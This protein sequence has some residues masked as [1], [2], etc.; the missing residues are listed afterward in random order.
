MHYHDITGTEQRKATV[1]PKDK[2]GRKQQAADK[3]VPSQVAPLSTERGG[4]VHQAKSSGAN[5]SNQHPAP[6]NPLG[7][8]QQAIAQSAVG[9]GIRHSLGMS[10]PSVATTHGTQAATTVAENS[11][12]PIPSGVQE[13]LSQLAS[14]YQNSIGDLPSYPEGVGSQDQSQGAG[15]AAYND[16]FPSLLSRNSSLVDLAMIPTLD[17][18]EPFISTPGMRFVD[19]PQPEVDPSNAPPGAYSDPN[20]QS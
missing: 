15:S 10:A 18:G 4:I 6:P 3:R 9:R 1:A 17:D 8:S 19:F 14:N 16:P 11:S 13:S 5:V 12:V 2:N 20:Q 7:N